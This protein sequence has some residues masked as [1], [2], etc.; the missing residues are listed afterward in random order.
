VD[1]LGALALDRAPRLL[2]ARR[3]DPSRRAVGRSVVDGEALT[4]CVDRRQRTSV[5]LAPTLRA[6]PPACFARGSPR[7]LE[8]QSPISIDYRRRSA[9]FRICYRSRVDEIVC[10]MSI[11]LAD[12]FAASSIGAQH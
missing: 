8:P 12:L 10:A 7:S 1:R 11:A 2:T 5:A 3:L 6:A 4:A 9:A